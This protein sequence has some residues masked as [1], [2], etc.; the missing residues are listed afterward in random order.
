MLTITIESDCG[1][2][3]RQ[4]GTVKAVHIA[5]LINK[6]AELLN[7]PEL[8]WYDFNHTFTHALIR[9][10]RDLDEEL[11]NDGMIKEG[12][13][14]HFPDDESELFRLV[15]RDNI[16]SELLTPEGI[17]MLVTLLERHNLI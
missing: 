5:W 10:L 16:V 7:F 17:E 8:S 15:P 12:M 1:R 2:I 6:M 3:T 11:E 13:L 14:G 4:V 9:F